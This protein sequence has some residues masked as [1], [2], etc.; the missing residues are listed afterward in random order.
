MIL[1]FSNKKADLYKK[2]TKFMIENS[3]KFQKCYHLTDFSLEQNIRSIENL[4]VLVSYK[5]R[6]NNQK[7]SEANNTGW[8]ESFLKEYE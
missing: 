3:I 2:I 6:K 4:N 7:K 8:N 1:R 5:S